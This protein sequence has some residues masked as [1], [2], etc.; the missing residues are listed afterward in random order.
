MQRKMFDVVISVASFAGL[1]LARAL[2]Q[3][4]DGTVRIA[5]IDK[6][7][8]PAVANDARAFAVWA[9]GK[10]VLDALGAWRALEASAEPMTAIEISD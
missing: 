9:G 2:Q 10:N 8:A 7:A 3:T 6:A 5:L 1:A 4:F